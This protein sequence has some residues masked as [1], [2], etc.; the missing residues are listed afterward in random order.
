MKRALYDLIIIGGGPSGYTA[1]LYA[2]R[3]GLSTLVLEPM[4]VGG[5]MVLTG[6]V[7]NYSGFD[8][9]I[10]GFELG[11]RMQRGAHRF[12]AKTKYETVT[13]LL[14]DGQI[15]RVVTDSGEHEARAVIIA[16]GA[17]ARRLGIAGEESLVGRGVHYCA[18]CDGGFYRD[19]R[20]VVIGGG[21]SAVGEAL[22]LA[23]ICERVTLV[24]RRDRLRATGPEVDALLSNDRTEVIYNAS[25]DG[26][27]TEGENLVGIRLRMGDGSERVLPTDAVFVSVGRT[28][29]TELVR[30]KL[31]LD[32]GGYIVAGEDT[33]TSVEG[34]FAAGDVRTK[35]LRQIV[36][37]TADGA[38]SAY[39]AEKYIG[40]L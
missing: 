40:A 26:F 25:P 5:Q 27:I 31:E 14:L 33:L 20:A 18:H 39:Q 19:R 34:V 16:T 32:G 6:T 7:E 24:H 17:V 35:P 4:Y 1:A 21:N 13:E 36:T 29:A 12:G 30:G 9:G 15:K 3:A 8:E 37:A 23:R 10:E 2:A 22:Y 11:A 38:V 28:P